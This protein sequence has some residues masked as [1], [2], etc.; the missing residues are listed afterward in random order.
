MVTVEDGKLG[1]DNIAEAKTTL[2]AFQQ[3]LK[4]T[5]YRER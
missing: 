2:W 3:Q 1:I 5:Q 4:K